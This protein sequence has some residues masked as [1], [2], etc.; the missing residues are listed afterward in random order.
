EPIVL[1]LP[2]TL[3]RYFLMPLLDAFT[4]VFASPG[5]RTT[6]TQAQDFAIVGPSWKG[7]LPAGLT[8]IDAPTNLVWLLGRT[9]IAGKDDLPADTAATDRYTLTPLPAYGRAYTPP[10]NA[11][12]DPTFDMATPP[13]E[14]IAKLDDEA[15]FTRLATLLARERP[16]LRDRA[17]LAR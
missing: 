6:G 17:A 12:I 14:L 13:P 8:R 16:P 15:F 11:Q 1:Q 5:K 3:G 9:E 4:N 7:T 2:D 10:E